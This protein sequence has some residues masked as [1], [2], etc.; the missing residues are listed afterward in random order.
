MPSMAKNTSLSKMT[1]EQLIA[2]FEKIVA[3][4]EGGQTP[5]EKSIELFE[6]GMQISAEGSRRLDEAE[7]KIHILVEQNGRAEKVPF[8]EGEEPQE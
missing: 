1:F 3:E 8:E 2:E 7:K 6:R 4:L 5:L